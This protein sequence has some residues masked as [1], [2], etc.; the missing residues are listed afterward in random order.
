MGSVIAA[1]TYFNKHR[2]LAQGALQSAFGAA[3]FMWAPLGEY[4]LRHFSLSGTFLI[5]AAI[6]LQGCV[7]GALLRP[8]SL[9]SK[10]IN[11]RKITLKTSD[12]EKTTA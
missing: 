11:S 9:H 3:Q 6:Q 4:L 7:F 5:F 1:Q 8:F 12:E 2:G 10:F